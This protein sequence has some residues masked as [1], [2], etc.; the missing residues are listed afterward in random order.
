MLR[1]GSKRL[2]RLIGFSGLALYGL[3]TSPAVT[4]GTKTAN[5][6]INLAAV[7]PQAAATRLDAKQLLAMANMYRIGEG[8]EKNPARAFDL[9][10]RAAMTGNAE[11][12]YQLATMYLESETISQS[13]DEAMKWLERAAAQG[14]KNAKFAY[15]YLLDN[16]YYV[17]C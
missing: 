13:E 11:A 15:S 6:A 3:M 2:A 8:V 4:A 9:Y 14:H 12:Q 7:S 5:T 17:G 10:R 16:M 1:K